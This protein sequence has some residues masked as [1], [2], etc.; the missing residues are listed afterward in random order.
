LLAQVARFARHLPLAMRIAARDV[1]RQRG[2]ALSG[3]GAIMASVTLLVALSIGAASDDEEA[4]AVYLPQATAGEGRI[5]LQQG[6][7]D[8]TQDPDLRVIER[9]LQA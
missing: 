7:A 8:P 1:G 9:Q 6:P 4:R 3:V 5:D 2:R